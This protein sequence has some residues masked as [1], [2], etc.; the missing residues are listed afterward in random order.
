MR[1][2]ARSRA[3]DVSIEPLDTFDTKEACDAKGRGNN[4]NF[5]KRQRGP[6]SKVE[7]PGLSA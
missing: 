2:D 3:G 7:S 6:E 4:A 5:A 1:P